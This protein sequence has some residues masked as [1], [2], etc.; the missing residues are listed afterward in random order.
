MAFKAL[1]GEVTVRELAAEDGGHPMMIHQW[2]PSLPEGAAGILGRGGK[3]AVAAKVA[4]ETGR[5]LHA[6]IGDRAIEAPS[7]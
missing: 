7:A 3:A 1:K 5:D 6:K 2:K 4:E